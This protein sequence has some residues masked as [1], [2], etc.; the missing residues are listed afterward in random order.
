MTKSDLVAYA[1]KQGIGIASHQY[2]TKAL[3]IEKILKNN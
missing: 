1:E 2:V 3:I